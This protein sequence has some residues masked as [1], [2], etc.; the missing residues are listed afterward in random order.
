MNVL[1]KYNSDIIKEEL[2]RIRSVSEK[3]KVA[4]L[5]V[6]YCYDNMII[7]WPNQAFRKTNSESLQDIEEYAQKLM[8]LLSMYDLCAIAH[9]H[10][11]SGDELYNDLNHHLGEFYG[12]LFVE[13]EIDALTQIEEYIDWVINL[14]KSHM[15][16]KAIQEALELPGKLEEKS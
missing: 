12:D 7:H 2:N 1:D 6:F 15:S 13:N 14:Y 11:Q 16:A 10:T 4:Q 5:L 8:H 9:K 3:I